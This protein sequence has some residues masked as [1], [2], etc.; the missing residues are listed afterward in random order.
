MSGPDTSSRLKP[1][2]AKAHQELSRAFPNIAARLRP[3]LEENVEIECPRGHSL[4]APR[5]LL[6]AGR[7]FFCPQCRQAFTPGGGEVDRQADTH[8]TTLVTAAP[9][10]AVAAPVGA[11]RGGSKTAQGLRRIAEGLVLL[12]AAGLRVL[13]RLFARC[14]GILGSMIVHAA[15]LALAAVIGVKIHRPAPEPE[16]PL[17]TDVRPPEKCE[18]MKRKRR[19]IFRRIDEQPEITEV[20]GPVRP[21]IVRQRPVEVDL[22]DLEIADVPE[23]AA[24]RA[25][26]DILTPSDLMTPVPRAGGV[27]LGL[28]RT[29]PPPKGVF[30]LRGDKDARLR[31]AKKYGG[32]A[33]TESAVEAAL[34]WLARNQNKDGSWGLN[35]KSDPRGRAWRGANS[36]SPS[37]TG[38]ALLA[39]LG[40]GYSHKSGHKHGEVVR[41]GLAW[42]VEKQAADGGFSG[43]GKRCGYSQGIC[44]MALAEACALGVRYSKK[45]GDFDR[46]LR[47][48]AQKAADFCA[49]SQNPYAGWDYSP[50][51]GTS[52]TSITI[53]NCLGLKSAR[54]AG[55]RVDG[56][57]FQGIVN[58]LNVAQDLSGGKG[59]GSNW[60]GGGFAYRGTPE[61]LKKWRRR[62]VR[63]GGGS[64]VMTAAGLMM[65]LYTGSKPG[66]REVTGPANMLVGMLPKE[67]AE[68]PTQ[69]EVKKAAEAW[70]KQAYGARFD[71][72]SEA[73]KARIRQAAEQRVRWQLTG[74]NGYYLRDVYFLYHST[75]PMFQIG[76][77]RWKRWNRHVKKHL[78]ETQ[79]KKGDDDGSWP[80][81]GRSMGR[82]MSTAM[83]AMI[84]EVYYRYLRVYEHEKRKQEEEREARK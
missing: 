36:Y 49:K 3:L 54:F 58:W 21:E 51:G 34:A 14:G 19:D 10:A 69:E 57:A 9:A 59:E 22:P 79:L 48:A 1:Y 81:G 4:S 63:F 38:F 52:D 62:G 61:S 45:P 68:E 28:G 56:A 15:L 53:W 72:Y 24:P 44:T 16:L 6:E 66:S 31:A 76:G 37:M 75:V 73:V 8:E 18:F 83:G 55:L 80:S 33:D 23:P 26:D 82:T 70:I 5:A 39:F 64:M 50:R 42:L 60:T 13:R 20:P 30:A 7:E 41:R 11:E 25:D 35:G 46:R 65:R 67:G 71:T 27:P 40:A 29:G 12:L 32:G 84:L 17:V 78:L 47:A 77:A 74:Q 2:D 43:R